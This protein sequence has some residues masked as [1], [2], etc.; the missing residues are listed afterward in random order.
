MLRKRAARRSVSLTIVLPDVSSPSSSSRPAAEHGSYRAGFAFGI[1]SF[2]SVMTLGVVSTI[3]TARIYGVRIVGQFALCYAPVAAMWV[4]STA[5]EQAAL[6]RE[7]TGLPP[8]H[9]RVTQLFA[10]V[11]TFS[12][13]LTLVVGVLAAAAA[14]LVFRGPLHHPGLV[15]PMLASIAGYVVVTNT[16]WNLD[17][18]F[19]AFVAGR[20]LFWIR[21]HET[22]SFL[23]I[24]TALGLA[25][26]SIWGLVLGTVGGSATALV[27]RIV[28]VR[29]FVRA[30]LTRAGYRAGLRVLPD[31]LRFGLKITPGSIAQGISSQAGV[32]AIGAVAPVATVGAYSR[33]QTIPDRLQQV[34][35][36]ITEVLYPTL[37]KRR[38]G[39]DG[40]GFDRALLDTIR[41]ALA[42]MLL[43]AALCGGAAHRILTLF[44][45][46]FA[47]ASAVLALLVLYPALAAIANAQTQAL[48]AVDR[49][50]LTSVIALTRM[51]LTLAATIVLTRAIGITGPAIALL[52]GYAFDIAWRGL[53]LR[54]HLHRRLH[55][56]WHWREQLALVVA[57]AAGFAAARAIVEAAPSLAGL[58]LAL[59][60]GTLAYAAVV[61]L[62]AVNARDRRRLGELAER[63]RARRQVAVHAEEP[64][65]VTG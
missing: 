54:P 53:A 55:A 19:S 42:G 52:A 27:H 11:F 31:L 30:R 4:L 23:A 62:G 63:L 33:A 1:L 41:Y 39:G 46:G 10:V 50:G 22:L 17:S 40:D 16:G 3:V 24:A 26:H 6:I 34:N 18:I 15:A 59:A 58:A 61:A 12:S 45:P 29:P 49:P 32:W 56:T 36:R 64:A 7:I 14:T 43:I 5:K 48:Y 9:P 60:A 44:G 20:Q 65:K 38:A 25:W 47:T 2:V 13:A 28:A 51:A 57:Y 35:V 21:L 8:R 37:V